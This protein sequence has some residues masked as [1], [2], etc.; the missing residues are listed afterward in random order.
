IDVTKIAKLGAVAAA[1]AILGVGYGAWVALEGPQHI[2]GPAQSAV[3]IAGISSDPAGLVV[4]TDNQ[5][6]TFNEAALGDSYVA[7][8]DANWHVQVDATLENGTYVGI[9][10][11][12]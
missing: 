8:R 7:Q 1:V 10:L 6:F 2:P 4:P 9:P 3:A 12:L 5:H 11:L